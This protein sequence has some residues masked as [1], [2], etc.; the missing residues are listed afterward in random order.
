[1]LK[2]NLLLVIALSLLG[3]GLM[4]QEAVRNCSTMDVHERLLTE[5]PSFATRMQNIEAFT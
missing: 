5:D 1:M 2:K 3:T 4:A